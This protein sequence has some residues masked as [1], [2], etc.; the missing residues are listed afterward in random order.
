[1]Y[2]VSVKSDYETLP[3]YLAPRPFS[4]GALCHRIHA[5]LNDPNI[6]PLKVSEEVVLEHHRR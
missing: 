1:M 5:I 6:G 2:Q 3:I 4:L